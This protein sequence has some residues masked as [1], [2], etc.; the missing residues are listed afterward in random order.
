M[1][2][3]DKSNVALTERQIFDAV[4]MVNYARSRSDQIDWVGIDGEEAQAIVDQ[5][6]QGL[7]HS[8]T[9]FD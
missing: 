4:K 1:Q 3:Q 8:E 5:L 7:N 9:I 2:K 6:L